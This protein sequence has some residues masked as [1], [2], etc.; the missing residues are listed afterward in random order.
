M[1]IRP[2]PD[3]GIVRD[4]VVH[5]EGYKEFREQLLTSDPKQRN[6]LLLKGIGFL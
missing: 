5:R 4:I 6:S 1:D 3:P 2:Q